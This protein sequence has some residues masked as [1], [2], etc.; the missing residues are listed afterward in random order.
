LSVSITRALLLGCDAETYALPLSS[1][2]ETVALGA[3]DVHVINDVG[4]LRWRGEIVP[5]LDLGVAFGT[6]RSLR[7]Q[8]YAVLLAGETTPRGLLVAELQGIREVVVKPL[9]EL[10]GRPQGISG[11]TV[12]GDG[13]AVLILDPR[14]LLDLSPRAGER[15]AA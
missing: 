13:R 2:L 12:L 9:D 1:V 7:R 15:S 14:G 3:T 4:V 6:A 10:A 11:S 8:G 5:L